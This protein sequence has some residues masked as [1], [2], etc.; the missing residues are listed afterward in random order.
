M[1][2]GKD[3]LMST[4][5]AADR[6]G[7]S[8]RTI[9]RW[10]KAGE[11]RGVRLGRRLFRVPES[12]VLRIIAETYEREDEELD[13]RDILDGVEHTLYVDR[14]KKIISPEEYEKY[15]QGAGDW[16]ELAAALRDRGGKEEINLAE[17]LEQADRDMGGAADRE[18][19]EI[20]AET[21]PDA[22]MGEE[23]KLRA[24]KKKPSSFGEEPQEEKPS[25]EP[26][27][28]PLEERIVE[29][30]KEPEAAPEPPKKRGRKKRTDKPRAELIEEYLKGTEEAKE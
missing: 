26:A 6:L 27:P 29:E 8:P 12:E 18:R 20:L 15:G 16:L 24:K 23:R 17:F 2:Q 7:V 11:L 3:R 10:I 1:E 30:P 19:I 21:N 5:E 9:A 28:E 22:A 13:P 14:G 25:G 4:A